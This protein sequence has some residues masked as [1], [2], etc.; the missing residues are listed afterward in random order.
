MNMCSHQSNAVSVAVFLELLQ[1]NV[2]RSTLANI[3]SNKFNAG[4]E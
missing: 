1:D 3:R 2:N 4:L